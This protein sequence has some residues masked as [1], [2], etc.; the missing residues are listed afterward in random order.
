MSR[1]MKYTFT[2]R[3]ISMGA[4]TP[5]SRIPKREDFREAS[6]RIKG[7]RAH[8]MSRSNR[9]MY[10]ALL[11][12]YHALTSCL[13]LRT[14]CYALKRRCTFLYFLGH[15]PLRIE[16]PVG[17]LT[18]RSITERATP[19]DN[20]VDRDTTSTSFT[21]NEINVLASNNVYRSP[22]SGAR[23]TTIRSE[24][25]PSFVH[26]SYVLDTLKSR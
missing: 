19:S 12:M 11:L 10:D 6:E 15:P 23:A 25:Y 14:I 24:W 7:V 21:D 16:V 26:A 5:S 22:D 8:A 3:L 20:V 17:E 2:H 18:E 13:T 1:K 4:S 9:S